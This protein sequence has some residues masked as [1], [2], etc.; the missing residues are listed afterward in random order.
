MGRYFHKACTFSKKLGTK[1][2]AIETIETV[3]DET[4]PTLGNRWKV[5]ILTKKIS[6]FRFKL[7]FFDI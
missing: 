2:N 4:Q 1:R 7:F 6:S 3:K 5:V